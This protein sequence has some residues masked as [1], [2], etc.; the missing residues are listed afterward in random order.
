MKTFSANSWSNIYHKDRPIC[1]CQRS[2]A[3]GERGGEEDRCRAQALS[4]AGP[5]RSSG[6]MGL[7]WVTP[8][9]VSSQPRAGKSPSD[10]AARPSEGSST[11][12]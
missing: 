9:T 5:W 8:S 1:C 6:L 3:Y 10:D 11:T 2:A 7:E 4:Q 12:W